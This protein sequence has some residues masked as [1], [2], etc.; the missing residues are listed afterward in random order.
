[1]HKK[2]VVFMLIISFL[3]TGCWD[4]IEVED[5]AHINALGIDKFDTVIED[6]SIKNRYVFTFSF[7]EHKKEIAKDIV[8]SSIGETLYSV[9]R[10]MASRSNRDFFLGHLRTVVIEADIAKIQK[11]FAK[12]LM[13]WRITD[14]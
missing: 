11:P 10:I 1:M 2:I 4:K 9:S 3:L 12:Y 13:E 7:P 14:F 6:D 8:V 5:R